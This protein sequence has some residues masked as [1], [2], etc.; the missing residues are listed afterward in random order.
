M[1]KEP[2]LVRHNQGL[3]DF[4]I[5][6]PMVKKLASLY[7]HVY[8]KVKNTSS[9]NSISQIYK[10][11]PNVSFNNNPPFLKKVDLN[12]KD[13]PRYQK[14]VNDNSKFN[15]KRNHKIENS[16]FKK[17]ISK[18][19]K[20][21]ILI[22]SR[23]KD[24]LGIELKPVNLDTVSKYN[25]NK[26]PIFNL[27][28]RSIFSSTNVFDYCTLLENAFQLHFYEGSFANLVDR[29]LK[30]ENIFC[31]VYCKEGTD[32]CADSA[33]YWIK[34]NKWHRLNWNYIY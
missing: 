11:T 8:L 21:Y 12:N 30:R 23:T 32:D 3:G 2:I 28:D 27:H 22:H 6:S 16:T 17:F 19:G 4:I 10:D 20:N 29:T 24:N 18:Y 5:F 34:R 13:F 9:L 26:F 1:L 14:L 15:I 7:S 31:H 25:P 33:I